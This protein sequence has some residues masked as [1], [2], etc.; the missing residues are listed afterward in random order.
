MLDQLR[1]HEDRQFRVERGKYFG[2]ALQLGHLDATGG[3][4]LRHLE[5]DV[6]GA[7]D[8]GRA[9][10]AFGEVGIEREGVPHGMDD[11]Y[12]VVGSELVETVDAGVGGQRAGADDQ[13]V[14]VDD[15]LAVVVTDGES[16]VS[17]IDSGCEGIQSQSH[18][19]RLQV[20][21]GAVGERLP[22]LDISGEVV[23]D[24]ADGVVRIARRRRRRS[25]RRWGRVLWRAARRRFP[26][27][28]RRWRRC[29][30][31]G[32][33]GSMARPLSRVTRARPERW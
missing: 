31:L 14:V 30:W 23:R 1:V 29:A 11:V 32:F 20:R 25:R 5:P 6:T 15:G 28:C 22:G 18:P 4:A 27:R 2:A 10:V 24:A 9:R 12:A 13:L 7:D 3:E 19:G 16:L 17:D 26:R 21:V 33:L 8:D